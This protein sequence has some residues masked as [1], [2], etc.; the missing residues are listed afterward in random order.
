MKKVLMFI[1]G[2]TMVLFMVG[3]VSGVTI[4]AESNDPHVSATVSLI[5]SNSYTV[6]IPS[7]FS[8]SQSTGTGQD[9]IQGQVFNIPATKNL[10]VTVSSASFGQAPKSD[11]SGL[12]TQ[13]WALVHDDGSSTDYLPYMI[14]SYNS[15]S[16]HIP[17]GLNG[18]SPIQNG[19]VVLDLPASS[20]DLKAPVYKYLHFKLVENDASYAGTYTDHLTFTVALT[21]T[22]SP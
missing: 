7:A 17:D 4:T 22:N 21:D 9:A 5:I 15:D 6:S 1:L 10:T 14:G 20:S 18:V 11:D 12:Y 2:I 19:D 13:A 8:I 3:G 16:T